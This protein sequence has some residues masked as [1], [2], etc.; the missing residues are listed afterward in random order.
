MSELDNFILSLESPD[1][2][3][4]DGAIDYADQ[5]SYEY[6]RDSAIGHAYRAGKKTGETKVEALKN[7]LICYAL[8]LKK[9]LIEEMND[10]ADSNE[11]DRFTLKEY[12]Q[13]K[14]EQEE[15]I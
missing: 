4:I 7:G 15:S 12:I 11:I 3:M 13:L 6:F 14:Q 9:A 1:Y 8:A 10:Y 5:C 2:Y